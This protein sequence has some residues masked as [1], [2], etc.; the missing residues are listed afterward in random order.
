MKAGG[1][2]RRSEDGVVMH[3]YLVRK[4]QPKVKKSKK[5]EEERHEEE[6]EGTI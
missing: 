1:R 2:E 3:E 6:S 5:K 4:L